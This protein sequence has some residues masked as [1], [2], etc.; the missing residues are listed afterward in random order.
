MLRWAT[1]Y[2]P[3]EAKC[4]QLRVIRQD[5]KDSRRKRY[6]DYKDSGDGWRHNVYSGQWGM[7]KGGRDA[8]MTEI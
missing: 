8:G 3:R 6:Q 5:Y 1:V 2:R 4:V 7:E